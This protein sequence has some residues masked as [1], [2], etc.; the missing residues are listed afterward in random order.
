MVGLWMVVGVWLVMGGGWL[1][2]GW[3]VGDGRWL[4]VVAWWLGRSAVARPT[5]A[6]SATTERATISEGEGAVREASEARGIGLRGSRLSQHV[7]RGDDLN[8]HGRGLK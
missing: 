7:L 5:K 1:A 4:R 8:T 6:A 3:L 2:G